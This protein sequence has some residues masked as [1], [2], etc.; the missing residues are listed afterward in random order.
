MPSDQYQDVLARLDDDLVAALNKH[1]LA[2]LGVGIVTPEG[3]IYTKGFGLAR[4]APETPATPETVFRIGSIA[5]TFTAIGLMQLWERGCFQLDDPVNDYLRTYRVEHADPRTPPVTFRHI[6]THTAGVGEFRSIRDLARP[7]IGLGAKPGAPVPS[8]NDYYA[9]RLRAELPPETKWAYAN[10]AF[11]TLGQL[12]EDLSGQPFATYMQERVFAPLGLTS[13][14]YL[15]SEQVS[16]RLATGYHLQRGRLKPVDY[17]EIVVRAAGSVFSTVDDLQRY[18]GFLLRGARD[19]GGAILQPETLRLM[20]APHYQVAPRLPAMG[21]AFVLDAIGGHRTAGHDGGWPGFVSQLLFAPDAGVGIVVLTN[22]SSPAPAA[23]GRDLLRR[24]LDAP[25]PASQIPRPGIWKRPHLWPDLC[26]FYGPTPG[27]NTNARL[28][29]GL[30]GE[31]EILVRDGQLHART[32]I[33]P[34]RGGVPLYPA[35]AQDPLIF[36]AIHDG[37][38]LTLVFQRDG[39]GRV[40][41]LAFAFHTFY[42][43]PAARSVRARALAGVGTLAALPLAAAGWRLLA[44]RR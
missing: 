37:Q 23:I 33:G 22:T 38:P 18:L 41:R 17:V 28:W 1:T 32:L 40:D 15:R 8:P 2:G 14:D 5:K 20:L 42:K 9:P 24:L 44:R 39:A 6:L 16:E 25:D 4:F 19:G 34:L 31:I 10:H 11:A 7:M 30:G 3:P 29:L 21:L 27:W 35:D 26:G 12:I 36:E 43:R 13:T